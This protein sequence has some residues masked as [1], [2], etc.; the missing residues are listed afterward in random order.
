[1]GAAVTWTG[2]HFV[3]L[4]QEA[5]FA[6]VVLVASALRLLNA[7]ALLRTSAGSLL[8]KTASLH[9]QAFLKSTISWLGL[10]TIGGLVLPALAVAG[11]LPMSSAMITLV[12][13][14]VG[15]LL[16]RRLFFK[17]VAPPRMPGVAI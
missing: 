6:K 17:T 11:I 9:W 16:E 3:A 5:V 10:W 4:P 2:A 1:L 8:T 13:L 15:D 7:L 14:L 12:A